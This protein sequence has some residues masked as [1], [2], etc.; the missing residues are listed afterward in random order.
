MGNNTRGRTSL[1]QFHTTRTSGLKRATYCTRDQLIFQN[2][3][4]FR[5]Q[6]FIFHA[7]GS[8]YLTSL[9]QAHA[10]PKTG[11]HAWRENMAQ[12]CS[13]RRIDDPQA[14]YHRFNNQFG[15]ELTDALN[16]LWNIPRWEG[17]GRM[18]EQGL[19]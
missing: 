8:T 4:Y 11:R 16:L 18:V 12:I 9:G 15:S 14:A 7:S 13:D 6:Y 2:K 1:Y 10:Y 5:R 3:N 17:E 19:Y